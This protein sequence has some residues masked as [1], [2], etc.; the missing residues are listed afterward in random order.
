MLPLIYQEFIERDLFF[1]IITAL[2]RLCFEVRK[3][4]FQLLV[5]LLRFEGNSSAGGNTP[6]AMHLSQATPN[7][8][9]DLLLGYLMPPES[10]LFKGMLLRESLKQECL[11]LKFL[12][13]NLSTYKCPQEALGLPVSDDSEAEPSVYSLLDMLL[14]FVQAPNYDIASDSFASLKEILTRHKDMV[15]EFL[16]T[17]YEKIFT[18]LHA[19][20]MTAN[21]LTKRQVLKLVGELLLDRSNYEVMSMYITSSAHMKLLMTL[22]RDKSHNIQYESFQ[23]FKL[24]LANP[25][26]PKQIVDIISNNKEKLL[27]FLKGFE[28]DFSG[29]DLDQFL[30]ER[31]YLIE[32]VEA[33]PSK[34]PTQQP[35]TAT[36]AGD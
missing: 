31:K 36:A 34:K 33:I 1:S 29:P 11:A 23:V 6:L 32:Q 16:E 24:F 20:I 3:D 27:A 14:E 2:P 17:N 13:S 30:D 7:I 26:K 10:A 15:A 5:T 4:A 8:L 21:Y 22:L 28:M 19:I 35:L 25:S 18:K 12:N 9:E